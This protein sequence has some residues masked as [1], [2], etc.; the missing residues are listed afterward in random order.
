MILENTINK[1]SKL[2]KNHNINSHKLDAELILAHIIGIKRELLIVNN[3]INISKNTGALMK[4][5][6]MLWKTEF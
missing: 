6:M 2:L 1:A 3:R 5:V 4:L